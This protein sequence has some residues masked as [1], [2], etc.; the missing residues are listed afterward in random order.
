MSFEAIAEAIHAV[1]GSTE[2]EPAILQEP[3]FAGNEEEYVSSCI[4]DGWV[5]SVGAFVDRF[6]RDLATYC[7]TNHAVVMVNG[8]TALHATMVAMGVKPGDEVLIPSLTF[9]ATANAVKHAGATPHFVDVET[10]SMGIDPE[11]L[12]QYLDKHTQRKGEGL[13]NVKTGKCIW[14]IM[15]VHVFGHPCKLDS[16]R[17]VARHYGLQLLEDATEALGSTHCNG[18]KI[19]SSGAAIFSFNGNKIITTGGGGALVTDD[20]QLAKRVKHI[21]TT[22]KLPHRWAFEHD[23]IAFNYRMPNLNAALGCAQLEMLPRILQAKR[24]LAKR[25]IEQFSE[26]ENLSIVTEPEG[27]ES[28]YWLV[29]LRLENN[30]YDAQALLGFLHEKNILARPVWKPLHSLSIYQDAP[31]APLPQTDHLAKN[32]INLPSSVKLGLA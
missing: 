1:I 3:Y 10:Q 12:T 30:A 28:N 5:S 22:A 2:S 16:L 24:A 26:L 13:Y 18:A 8:T 27:S 29:T 23:E 4:R 20:A 25:Y 21:T 9:V 32:I 19:G 31:R 14:G 17:D 6:E 7:Q 11:A 15:P